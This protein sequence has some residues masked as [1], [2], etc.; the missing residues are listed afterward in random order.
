V[1][2]SL[3]LGTLCHQASQLTT[4][5]EPQTGESLE[6]AN[7]KISQRN[8]L[9]IVASTS[10]STLHNNKLMSNEYRKPILMKSP[11]KPNIITF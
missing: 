9:Q 5:S 6:P 1:S 7:F 8:S 3:A 2:S 4:L 11:L 10:A